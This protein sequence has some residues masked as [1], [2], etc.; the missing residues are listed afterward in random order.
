[1]SES[2]YPVYA[3][4]DVYEYH[5]E[6]VLTENEKIVYDE[7]VEAYLQFRT[8]FSTSVKH[9]SVDELNNAFKAV[10]LDHPEIFWTRTFSSTNFFSN[11]DISRII[12]LN[13]FYS[14]DDAIKIKR[15]IEPKYNAI[16]EEAKKYNSDWDKIR[17]VHDKLIEIGTYEDYTNNEEGDFQSFVSIFRDGRTVC[18]GY[19]HAFKYIMDNLGIKSVVIVDIN[20]ED[21]P[22]ESHIWNM[23]LND[24]KWYNLDITYDDQ[25]SEE[26]GYICYTYFMIKNEIFYLDHEIQEDVPRNK[27]W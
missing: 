24:G 21:D 16:I 17:Y 25:I 9:L 11:V 14:K 20:D 15:E 2:S 10:I 22:V 7:I 8:E 27:E 6:E 4:Q 3:H 26:K 19:A 18:T 13:Y 12:R 1:M 23:V 5:K